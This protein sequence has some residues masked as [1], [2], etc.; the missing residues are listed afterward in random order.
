M[1]TYGDLAIIY[2]KLKNAT[3]YQSFELEAHDVE[4]IGL[5]RNEKVTKSELIMVYDTLIHVLHGDE[6]IYSDKGNKFFLK[7]GECI[8]IPKG[9][10]VSATGIPTDSPHIGS[11]I[12]FL[13]EIIK[14]YN[15]RVCKSNSS[16]IVSTNAVQKIDT[17]EVIECLKTFEPLFKIKSGKIALLIKAKVIELLLL[18]E[19]KSPLHFL[20][21]SQIQRG[22]DKIPLVKDLDLNESMSLEEMSKRLGLSLSTFKREFKKAFNEPAKQW[23]LKKKLEKAYYLLITS[24]KSIKEIS[25]TCGFS[26]SSHFIRSFKRTYGYSPGAMNKQNVEI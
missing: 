24:T 11:V 4:I 6:L 16:L 8:F 13:P 3:E 22:Q 19:N 20:R 26:D 21:T 10:L 12:S 14:E 1:A 18:L 7:K 25:A 17:P 23:L 15:H 9:S 2:P 5:C